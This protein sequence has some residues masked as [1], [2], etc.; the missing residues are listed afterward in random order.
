M[1][2]FQCD[3]LMNMGF[4]RVGKNVKLSTN[5][6]IYDHGEIELFDNCRIDDFCVVSGKVSIGR[7]VHVTP[8]CLIAG[9]KPGIFLEDFSTTAYGVKIFAQSDDYSGESMTNSLMPKVYKNERFASVTVGRFAILGAGATVLPGANIGEGGAI[10]AMSLV[11]RPTEPWSI[12][13]GVPAIKIKA[14]SKKLLEKF[15]E[16]QSLNNAQ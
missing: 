12:Y 3:D 10:G 11:L 15:S 6:A 8:Q 5:A 16:W 13:A 1:P 2:Y 7:N 4:K 9:G 14:R